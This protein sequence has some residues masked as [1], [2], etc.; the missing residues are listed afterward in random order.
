MTISVYSQRPL[1]AISTITQVKHTFL[2]E[3]FVSFWRN[4][5]MKHWE[6]G[7]FKLTMQ[8][9]CWYKQKNNK[10]LV[11]SPQNKVIET[12]GRER[13]A[14]LITRST[15]PQSP[16]YTRAVKIKSSQ[17][18]WHTPLIPALGRQR[19]VDYEFSSRPAW[20]T[21]WV[22]GQP[23]LYRESLSRKKQTKNKHTNK[24]TKP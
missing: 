13:I 14:W 2:H 12:E 7:V 19:Q 16:P 1:V 24:Q 9:L 5:S 3:I 8:C 20:F 6:K 15:I 23:G 22:P 21:R 18:W 10:T 17:A 11:Q 4:L